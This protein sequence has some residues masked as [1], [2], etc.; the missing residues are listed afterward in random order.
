MKNPSTSG[1]V[2]TAA[3]LGVSLLCGLRAEA[4]DRFS[5]ERGVLPRGTTYQIRVPENWNHV[6]INDL[7]FAA[8]P[9]SPKY[10]YWLSKGY[11]VSGTARRSEQPLGYDP[12]KEIDDLVTVLDVFEAKHGKP[13]RTIQYGSSGGGYDALMMAE[14]RASR[15]D[16]AVA[17]CALN[18]VWMMNSELDAW[19]SLQQLIAPKLP[20]VN[21]AGNRDTPPALAATALWREAIT[22]AQTTPLGRA[23]I[24]LATTLG[25]APAWVSLTTPEPDPKDMQALQQST[26]ESF[27]SRAGRQLGG[28]ARFMFE[29]AAP[30]Q[31]SWNTG[32]DYKELFDRGDEDYKRAVRTLYREA[33]ASLEDDLRT[34]NEA[35]R[36]AADPK[37]IK[38]WSMPGRT[39]E[40]KPK[41]PVF[42]MHT[43]GDPAVTVNIVEG[44]DRIVAQN[45]YGELY[46]RAFVNR[47][48]H[49]TFSV[50]ESAAAVETL[51]RRLDTGEWGSTEPKD[52]NALG[53]TLDPT[54][55]ARFY[56]F[57]QV[58]Y[59]RVWLPTVQDLIGP[60]PGNSGK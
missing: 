26:Y 40:G 1:S 25:Q 31:L 14:Y 19:F 54:S 27:M 45:G 28:Q 57:R 16:G 41:V 38:W 5:N 42:R 15:I 7:D 37:A 55:E 39:Y 10:L 59:N 18:V 24:A 52:L 36:I 47:P 29:L 43:N 3:V 44:Y 17:V 33:G 51:M 46:R 21:P 49:C 4:Q 6:L 53:E 34:I 12:A 58:E 22:E 60:P 23:R 2:A 8:D 13:D 56:D 50:A 48:G 30:G 20:V 32:I 9:D 11:A 35:S